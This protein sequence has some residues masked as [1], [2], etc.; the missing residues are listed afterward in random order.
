MGG[1]DPCCGETVGV[2]IADPAA[3]LLLFAR[4]QPPPGVAP[5]AGH[6]G[7]H[8]TFEAAAR[9]EVAEEVG[10]SVVRLEELAR[11]WRGSWCRRGSA[12][13]MWRI[14]LADVTGEVRLKP[15]EAADAAWYTPAQVQALAGR[16]VAHA[17][18]QVTATEFNA[19]PGLEP[20]W[21]LWLAGLGHITVPLAD[22]AAVEA[23]A[24]QAPEGVR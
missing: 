9:A 20:V 3:R 1:Y 2:L 22:L 16:T 19:D 13:H 7:E 21:V 8:G 4:R 14:Y 18:G 24:R 23:L 11:G 5:V 12:G 10:L 15:D 17:R 6:V